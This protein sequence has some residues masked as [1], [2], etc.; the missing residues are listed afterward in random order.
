M[1]RRL[2]FFFTVSIF[3]YNV[4]RVGVLVLRQRQSVCVYVRVWVVYASALKRR[5]TKL[6]AKVSY[7]CYTIFFLLQHCEYEKQTDRL[8]KDDVLLLLVNRSR[9]VQLI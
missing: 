6:A 5:H 3:F 8:E 2:L 7:D 9:M 4:L 1:S